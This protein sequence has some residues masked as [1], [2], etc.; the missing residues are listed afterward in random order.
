M[1]TSSGPHGNERRVP[2][3]LT[4]GCRF[5]TSTG[6]DLTL[7]EE[8]QGRWEGAGYPSPSAARVR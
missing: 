5:D 3:A 4:T 8:V 7:W 1:R 2:A 6:L